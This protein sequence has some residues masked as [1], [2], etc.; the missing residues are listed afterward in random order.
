MSN[1]NRRPPWAALRHHL[2]DVKTWNDDNIMTLTK[3]I[4]RSSG[5]VTLGKPASARTI[6]P[7]RFW[8]RG[9]CLQRG[10]KDDRL[11]P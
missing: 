11:Q 10:D 6:N 2:H 1:T 7:R 9:G 4:G 5:I 3:T 8:R